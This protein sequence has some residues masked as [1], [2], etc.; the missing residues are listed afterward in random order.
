MTLSLTLARMCSMTYGDIDP[1][2]QLDGHLYT[3]KSFQYE[4]AVGV[5]FENERF[6]I[7]AFRGTDD[8]KDV[9]SDIRVSGVPFKDAGQ[10]HCG[11]LE[12]YLK[13]KPFLD[14]LCLQTRKQLIFTGHS[15]GGSMAY[16][17]A[18]DFIDQAP[19]C[20]VTFGMPRT[21]TYEFI[22]NPKFSHLTV[23][24]WVN[25]RDI[26]VRLPSLRFSHC[27]S[28]RHLEDERGKLRR[29]LRRRAYHKI[30]HYVKSLSRKKDLI[31]LPYEKLLF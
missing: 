18:C 8:I 14:T 9:C 6:V 10:V 3:T 28:A 5:A 11:F 27:G 2:V 13:V 15:L 19:M 22:I 7:I 12:E 30:K 1:T 17:A 24:R 23:V 26:V 25:S 21:A 4:N 16:L 29:V 31:L 20:V